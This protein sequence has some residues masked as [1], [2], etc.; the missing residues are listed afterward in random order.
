MSFGLRRL[1]LTLSPS[2]SNLPKI[3]AGSGAVAIFSAR[4]PE[5]QDFEDIS[6]KNAGTPSGHT[7]PTAA[8]QASSIS[9]MSA[10][11]AVSEVPKLSTKQEASS[12]SA[13]PTIPAPSPRP[14]QLSSHLRDRSPYHPAAATYYKMARRIDVRPSHAENMGTL[15]RLHGLQIALHPTN[16]CHPQLLSGPGGFRWIR[17]LL[18]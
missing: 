4:V 18:K 16:F 11:S 5:T 2:C 13:V 1:P 10:V 9:L 3:P 12:P 17:W 6:Y 8:F 15:T 14:S 7:S